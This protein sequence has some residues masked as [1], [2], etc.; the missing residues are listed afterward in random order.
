MNEIKEYIKNIEYKESINVLLKKLNKDIILNH[1]ENEV[2]V[3]A[4]LIKIP[5]MFA[6]L[7]KIKD[8]NIDLNKTINID[9][10]DILD[11]NEVFKKDK[12]NYTIKELINWMIVV[13][14]NSSTN[15]LIKYL[16]FNYINDFMKKIGLNNTILQRY[17]ND[18][19][20]VEDGYNNYTSLIDMY[21]CF[22]LLINKKILNDDLCDLALNI[23]YDQRINNQIPKYIEN[24]KFAHKTGGLDHLNSDVGIFK[25]D[26]EIYFIGISIYNVPDINGD[27]ESVS[28]LSKMIY[29]HL[30]SIKE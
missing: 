13:S 16:G 30:I 10:K 2:F 27:R 9:K 5:I 25:I 20:A 22:E 21:K 8:D 26:N 17:M 23:L 4:S 29:N 1:K 15:I 19:K 18:F 3:S 12:Y 28:I 24:I 6:I 11:D 7:N 14:D